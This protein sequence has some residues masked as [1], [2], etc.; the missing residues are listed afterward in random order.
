M[1]VV[2]SLLCKILVFVDTLGSVNPDVEKIHAEIREMIIQLIKQNLI[3]TIKSLYKIY[4]ENDAQPT[5]PPVIA[6]INPALTD[7][8]RDL[9]NLMRKEPEFDGFIRSHFPDWTHVHNALSHVTHTLNY[10]P[11][12]SHIRLNSNEN[13]YA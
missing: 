1:Y 8:H 12:K 3:E 13:I 11:D 10:K 6:K 2:L 4:R 9:F 7:K 5:M